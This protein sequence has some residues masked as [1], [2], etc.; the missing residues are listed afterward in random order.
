[1]SDEQGVNNRRKGFPLPGEV[2]GDVPLA[3]SSSEQGLLAD[4]DREAIAAMEEVP[5]LL[6]QFSPDCIQIN[7]NVLDQRIREN[8]LLKLCAD[9][10]V[11]CILRTPLCFGFLSGTVNADPD[12]SPSDHRHR[13]SPRQRA[14]WCGLR[15]PK[16]LRALQSKTI[17]LLLNW[18]CASACRIGVHRQPYRAC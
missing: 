3:V 18:L 16:I 15:R 2:P 5:V 11:V 9:Q 17:P 7:F 14:L 4:A 6:K 12:F 10:S 8:G 1:V 13:W